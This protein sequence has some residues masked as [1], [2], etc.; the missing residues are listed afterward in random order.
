MRVLVT[1]AGTRL[2]QEFAASLAADR[3]VLLTGRGD[4]PAAYDGIEVAHSEL[5]HDDSTRELVRGVDAIVHNGEPDAGV[6]ASGQLDA[7]MRCTYNLLQAASA[8]KVSRLVYLSSLSIM[9]RYGEDYAVTERWR[10]A[11]DT[12]PPELAYHLGEHVC[13]E[14]A[15]ERQIAVVCLRLGELVWDGEPPSTSAL[16]P[17][18]AAHAVARAL[19]WKADEAEILRFWNGAFDATGWDIF[20]IQSEVPNQRYLIAEARKRLRYIPRPRP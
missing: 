7:A 20:H 17:D 11:P 3:D 6:E 10:P 16:Y 8:E 15:R 9:G 4:A 1:G 19:D 2:S 12:E 13:R 14:F 5:G 18:D